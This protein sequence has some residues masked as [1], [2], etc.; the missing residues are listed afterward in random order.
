MNLNGASTSVGAGGSSVPSCDTDG[1]SVIPNLSSGNVVSATVGGIAAGCGGATLNLAVNN[2]TANSS[3]WATVP[4]GGGSLTV[5][6]A[7]AVPGTDVEQID[8][9]IA[10]P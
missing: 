5:T 1:V 10:G 8:L 4:G 6:L 7:S 2:G 9:T 3:G